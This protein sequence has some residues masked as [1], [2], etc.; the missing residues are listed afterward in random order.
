MTTQNRPTV[1]EPLVR[2]HAEDAAFYW[3]QHDASAESPRLDLSGLSR[4]GQLLAAHLEGLEVAGP[5][6]WPLCLAALERW[7]K[8]AEAFVAAHTALGAAEASQSEALLVQIRARPDELLRGVISAL[9]WFPFARARTVIEEWTGAR[10]DAV[11]QAA[12]LRSVALIGADAFAAIGQPLDRFLNSSDEHVRAAAC[13]VAALLPSEDWLY[14]TL[15]E[16]LLDPVLAVRA[17]AAIALGS[18][19][20]GGGSSGDDG[21]EVAQALSEC[22]AAQVAVLNASTGWYRK[23]AMRRLNRWV[24]HLAARLFVELDIAALLDMLPS[25]LSLRF[26]AYHGDSAHL[27]YVVKQMNIPS[28]ALYAGWVWQTVTGVDISAADLS[29]PEPPLDIETEAI[30]EVPMD[31]DLGLARP[32]VEAIRRFSTANLVDGQ[33]YLLGLALNPT[34]ALTVMRTAP[35]AQ[36][37][38][39]AHYLQ[40]RYPHKRISVRA[41]VLRQLAAIDQM[42]ALL[43]DER[44]R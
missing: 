34:N 28:E 29:L 42:Q 22:V 40:L 36:R 6:A 39:A 31:A 1:I 24:Q 33:R 26:V 7:K 12:A 37:T 30:R 41:P 43:D 19:H 5:A 23:Q 44:V 13:R 25:R 18:G 20:L 14:S 16:R 35:Q 10:S 8:P 2:R 32:D 17:E 21:V 11:M 15:V 4:F 3:A 38:I 27:P 9:A